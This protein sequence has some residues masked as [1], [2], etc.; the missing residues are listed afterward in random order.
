MSVL[1]PHQRSCYY[2]WVDQVGEKVG[3]YFA[4]Q[5]GGNFEID[6]SVTSPSNKIIVDGS[7]ERQADIIFTGQEIGEYTFCFEEPAFAGD[8]LVD[9]DITVESEP[10]LSM[11]LN[12]SAL[13]SDHSAPLESS[14]SKVQEQLTDITR[15]QR[16]FRTWEN[17]GFDLVRSTK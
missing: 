4:V 16:Y 3:W 13:L 11:P 1:S 5:S 12:P 2:A 9:F 17:R 8:K 14:I 10:R 7:K 6:W 15:T